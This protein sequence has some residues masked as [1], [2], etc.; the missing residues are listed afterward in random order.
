[1]SFTSEQLRDI[2]E[3]EDY[4]LIHQLTEAIRQE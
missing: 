3:E 2:D 1:M 4:D